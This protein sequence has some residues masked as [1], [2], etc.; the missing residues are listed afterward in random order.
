M[1][2]A[3]D[4]ELSPDEIAEILRIFADSSMEELRLQ[5][6][7]TVV[8]ASKLAGGL[9][10]RHDVTNA[11]TAARET[12]VDEATA[13]VARSPEPTLPSGDPAQGPDSSGPTPAGML[14]L[15]SPLLGVFYRRPAPDQPAFVEIGQEVGPED[16]VCIIDVMKMFTRVPAGLRGRLAE[17]LVDDGAL[18]EHGQI[19]MRFD[20]A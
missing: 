1:D 20:P 10:A 16:P 4:R 5:V 3:E 11:G 2:N 6:G 12:T 18:V 7:E 19:L 8:H 17:V 14:E 9:G 13:S 15:T